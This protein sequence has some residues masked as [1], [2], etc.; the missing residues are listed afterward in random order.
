MH[1]ASTNDGARTDTLPIVEHRTDRSPTPQC[2]PGT[3]ALGG[4]ARGK[5]N[6]ATMRRR[7]NKETSRSQQ[8]SD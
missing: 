7:S 1:A 5:R 2:T 6:N 4:G 3:V 8:V